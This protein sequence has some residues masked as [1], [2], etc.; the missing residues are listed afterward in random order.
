MQS[1]SKTAHDAL[2]PKTW[3]AS[4]RRL[5]PVIWSTDSIGRKYPQFVRDGQ[6]VGTPAQREAAAKEAA[7]VAEREDTLRRQ[8][9]Q[10]T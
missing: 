2:A 9:M 1:P 10:A 3:T 4:W 5:H 7:R 8:S 6:F